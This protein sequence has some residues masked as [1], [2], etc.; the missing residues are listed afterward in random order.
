MR[1][2]KARKIARF[3]SIFA[4]DDHDTPIEEKPSPPNNVLRLEL[5]RNGFTP[6]ERAADSTDAAGE[7]ATGEIKSRLEAALARLKAEVAEDEPAQA[8]MAE[9]RSLA[10]SGEAK[11]LSL[12]KPPMPTAD[13]P[14]PRAELENRRSELFALVRGAVT[15][16]HALEEKYQQAEQRLEQETAQRLVAEQRLH[17]LEDEYLQRLAAA[18][19]EEL[20]R[21]EAELAREEAEARLQ[22]A[23]GRVRE[24]ESRV[25]AEAD[26]RALA[27]QALDEAETRARAASQALTA[28]EQKRTEAEQNA[29]RAEQNARDIEALVGEAEAIAHAAGERYKAAEARLQ[30]ESQL[31]ALAEQ[32]L[33]AFEDELGSCLELNWAEMEATA[34]PVIARPTLTEA[35]LEAD[36]RLPQLQAQTEAEQK[37]RVEAE[38]ARAAAETRARELEAEMRK[39]EEKHRR[40]ETDL[41][42]FLRKQEAELRKQETELRALRENQLQAASLSLP[43]E[44]EREAE[45]IPPSLKIKLLSY[46]AVLTFLLLALAWLVTTLF[47]Q[48]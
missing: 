27:E 9:P 10:S 5:P 22:E 7:G 20:K 38:Q 31:R 13:T 28:A 24:I 30:Q 34:M 16:T 3:S 11:V 43:A 41:K 29:R 2:N 26:L 37:R 25:Q 35:N 44:T 47:R 32:K 15:R 33:K 14:G 18:E 36:A 46:G 19:A 12:A 4:T 23:V 40:A 6:Q 39:L 45:P 42:K 8:E 17:E 48:V 21:L 1:I